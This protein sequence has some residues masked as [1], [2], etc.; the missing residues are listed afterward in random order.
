MMF[1]IRFWR[2]LTKRTVLGVLNMKYKF[3]YT[4]F[5]DLFYGSGFY[6]LDPDF[7]AIRILTQKK[8]PLW[9]QKKTDLK[10]CLFP[11]SVSGL[12]KNPDP[13]WRIRSPYPWKKCPKTVSTRTKNF[14]LLFSTLKFSSLSFLFLQNL[15]KNVQISL[16]C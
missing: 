14:Y 7:W 5:L 6:V 13:I 12:A 9:I 10:H 11:E 3:C 16:V 8:S 1:L 15:F 4:Q 2:N